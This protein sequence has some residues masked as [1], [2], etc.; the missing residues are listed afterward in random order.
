MESP[1]EA[2]F[3]LTNDIG[4]ERVRPSAAPSCGQPGNAGCRVDQGHRVG[5]ET[6]RFGYAQLDE[7]KLA[8]RQDAFAIGARAAR[9]QSR[10]A[11]QHRNSSEAWLL[12]RA[13]A[14]R[15]A[16]EE[17]VLASITGANGSGMAL[18]DQR[19]IRWRPPGM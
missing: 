10:A 15:L 9:C 17:R 8:R 7:R 12:P 1:F 16:P 2:G 3:E 5:R 4:N 14:V 6:C 19:V 11:L 13:V 18:T